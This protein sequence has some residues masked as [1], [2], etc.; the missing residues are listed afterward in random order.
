MSKIVVTNFSGN[1]GKSTISRHLLAPRMNNAT[2]IPVESINSDGSDDVAIKGRQFAELMEA[3]AVMD[4]AVVDVGASNVEDFLGQMKDYRG[5]HEDFDYFVVPTVPKKKQI[6][7]TIATIDTLAE[8]GVPA[9]KIRVVFNMVDRD[10][11][12][13]RAFSGLFEYH[14][15]EKNFTLRPGAVIQVSEIFGK[16]GNGSIKD[17]LNDTTDLKAELQAANDP[18]AK[19]AISRR[20]AIKRLAVGVNEELDAVHKTLFAK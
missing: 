9:D 11:D 16:I 20:I 7:D 8:I 17:I 12:V 15:D 10:E 6:R 3:L 13:E 1:A 4:N 5:S 2:V 14:K 19:L 18:D